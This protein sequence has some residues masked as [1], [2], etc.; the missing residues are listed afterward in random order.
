VFHSGTWDRLEG[1]LI[2]VEKEL[3]LPHV[4]R[5]TDSSQV[6]VYEML[7]AD[8]DGALTTSLMD[9]A[10]LLKDNRLLPK[11][12]R[13][14]GPDA[15]ATRA[16]GVH[17][18]DDFAPGRDTVTYVVKT[19]PAATATTLVIARLLYQPIPPA[20]ALSLEEPATDEAAAFLH[21]FHTRM[22]V[23]EL[24]AIATVTIAH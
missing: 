17:D 1:T 3:G 10:S 6:A 18:D 16:I 19:P 23:P 21:M 2:G 24:L 12:W 13:K 14:D 22:P 20:W 11:G 4:D 7:A 5:I 15:A 8:R 9:M